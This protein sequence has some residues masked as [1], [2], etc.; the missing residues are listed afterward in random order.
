MRSFRRTTPIALALVL[1][2]ASA[3]AGAA[4]AEHVV[5]AADIQRALGQKTAADA[6]RATILG[7]LERPDVK[8]LTARSG[9]DLRRAESAVGTLEGDDL[10]RLAQYASSAERDLAGGDTKITISLVAL[11]L[12]IIIVILL[13]K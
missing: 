7:L 9:L 3:P 4:T 1:L 12:I 2:A 5:S 8:E 13:V 11:L 6:Q 10:A